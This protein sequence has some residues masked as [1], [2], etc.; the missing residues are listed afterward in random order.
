MFK[1]LLCLIVD[2]FLMISFSAIVCADAPELKIFPVEACHVE[3]PSPDTNYANR[4]SMLVKEGSRS[5][6]LKFD[7]S[8][9]KEWLAQNK[10][11]EIDTAKLAMTSVGDWKEGVVT[12]LDAIPALFYVPDDSWNQSEV[13]YRNQPAIGAQFTDNSVTLPAGVKT[14]SFELDITSAVKNELET[15]TLPSMSLQH[16]L[17]ATNTSRSYASLA[18]GKEEYRPQ[19]IVS[20]KEKEFYNALS[21][22]AFYNAAGE[23]ISAVSAGNVTAVANLV[24][25]D[26]SAV[27][28][29]LFGALYKRNAAGAEQMADLKASMPVR[30]SAAGMQQ[31][32]C[33]FTVPAD[34]EYFIRLWVTDGIASQKVYSSELL[35]DADGIR[36]N[37]GRQTSKFTF[38]NK[39]ADVNRQSGVV[40]ISADTG[41]VEKNFGLLVLDGQTD[42]NGITPENIAEHVVYAGVAQAE[43]GAVGKAFTVAE[44]V[45]YQSY[46]A[47]IDNIDAED[48][49]AKLEFEY[50]LDGVEDCLLYTSDAADD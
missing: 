38:A 30:L 32:I 45:Y 19:M 27:D 43:N 4:A 33:E 5:A 48:G 9:L 26:G 25:W 22:V 17:L 40:T 10:D 15:D 16:V 37:W 24:S 12:T 47:Y 44:N 39:K 13:T 46:A 11:Y 29:T 8:A 2:V 49:A 50:Y 34:G 28:A 7:L 3:S 35:F 41:N 18:Y 36:Q 1:K 23:E 42:V 20:F 14:Y 31:G 21:S 6:F